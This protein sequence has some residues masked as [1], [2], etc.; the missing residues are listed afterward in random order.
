MEKHRTKIKTNGKSVRTLTEE[1]QVI[2][3]LLANGAERIT[4]A[5]AKKEPYKTWI[6]KL[7]YELAHEC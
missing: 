2:Q 7:K 1:E 6:T 3:K 5:M 4:P